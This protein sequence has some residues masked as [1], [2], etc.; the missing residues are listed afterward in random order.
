MQPGKQRQSYLQSKE[1][2][3]GQIIPPPPANISCPHSWNLDIA[4]CG[5]WGFVNMIKL[6]TLEAIVYYVGMP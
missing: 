4:F 3:A 2:I 5:K 6:G 1:D